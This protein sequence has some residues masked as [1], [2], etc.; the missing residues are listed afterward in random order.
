MECTR[1]HHSAT[2]KLK[3]SVHQLPTS[4]H[5]HFGALLERRFS[6][7]DHHIRQLLESFLDLETVSGELLALGLGVSIDVLDEGL[8]RPVLG[9]VVFE[10]K[11]L[12]DVHHQSIDPSRFQIDNAIDEGVEFVESFSGRREVGLEVD[13]CPSQ[14]HEART[15]KSI[16]LVEARNKISVFHWLHKFIHQ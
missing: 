7:L 1:T 11:T 5:F 16:D 6:S 9:L 2:S 12:T 15:K 8:Q 3:Q 14:R 10:Q 4:R 13:R